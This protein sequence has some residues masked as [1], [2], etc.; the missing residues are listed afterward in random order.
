MSSWRF[1]LR[2]S[3]RDLRRRWLQVLATSLVIAIGTGLYAGL[4]GM[5]EWRERSNDQS[6]AQLAYHDL[7]VDLSQGSYVRAG[8]LEA[9]MNALPDVSAAEERMIVPTQ[10]DASGDGRTVLVPGQIVGMPLPA[11]GTRVDKL[12]ARAGRGL[13]AGDAR[14]DVVVLHRP[15]AEHYGL[16]PAGRVRLAGLGPVRYVGQALSPQ[17]FLV[18]DTGSFG[19][20]ATFAVVHAPLRLAQRAAGRPGQVNEG[21]LRL[22]PG[23]DVG[24]AERALRAALEREL[25]G[26]GTTITRG[27][28]EPAYRVLYKDAR[29]DQRLFDV[30]AYLVLGG[31]ALAAFNLISRVVES[32]RREIGVGM[33]LG[34]PPRALALRPVLMGAQIA[35]LGVALG[36][37][38]GVA[39]AEWLGA[40]FRE[41]LPLPSYATAFRTDVFVRAAALGFLL[42]LAATAYPVWRGVRVP[43]IEAIR[44]GFRAAKGGG[45]A[46]L[47][48][49]IR[50]PGSS[51]AQMP[52]RNV[53]R[54]PRR[55]IMTILGLAAVITTV[56]SLSGMFDSFAAT[57]DSIEDES[58]HRGANRVDVR[59]DDYYAR[60]SRVV[61]GVE[62]ARKVAAAEATLR[63]ESELRSDGRSIDVSVALLDPRSAIWS[64]T[65]EEGALR[66]GDRG[67]VIARKA[68]DDLGLAVGD[69]LTLRH[70]VRRGGAFDLADT[71]L[72]VIGVHPSPLRL[73]AY[74]DAGQSPLLGLEGQANEVTVLPASGL[75]EQEVQRG[76]FG[77]PGVAS[78]QPAATE[79]R[80]IKQAVDEF[81]EVITVTETVTLFLA[82]LMAFNSTSISVDERRREYAT[83]FAFGVPVRSG[84]RLAM[85]E[86]MFVGALGTLIGLAVG[87]A[88]VNW[89]MKDLLGE[90]LPDL[91]AV[92]ALS[93]ASIATAVAVGIGAVTL[94]P[95]LTSRRLRRM[96]IP[97][98]L[99]VVE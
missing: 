7:R 77:R 24:R 78:V 20:E 15:F 69:E 70:P 14:A 58:L 25:P 71:R 62:R 48:K 88:L 9:V 26:I 83:L 64:P 91:G 4:G 61:R 92:V 60:D 38:T 55:T 29:S 32:E 73:L 52:L 41:Q 33:A 50:L 68:A 85:V 6:F 76:L 72:P 99:R 39:F 98:T 21:V 8:R 43:P 37:A 28:E 94:A 10:V 80:E 79:T 27:T 57:V 56:V 16:P 51:L 44:V 13:G 63:V 65:V 53:V 40:V 97:S 90:T 12:A 22:A 96:D 93:P 1:W 87:V 19:G 84:L 36:I 46:P 81:T 74:M 82:L 3:W 66:R 95:L 35:L 23:A 47:L 2:W 30:F 89:T 67:I 75:S 59:L 86:S 34:V 31:A 18:S 11:G 54:A 17:F 42:P 49:R 5:R 45:F